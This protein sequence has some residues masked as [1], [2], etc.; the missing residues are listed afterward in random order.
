MLLRMSDGGKHGGPPEDQP[1]PLPPDQPSP[2]GSR[3]QPK[4][5]S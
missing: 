2:D 3:P 5:A 4:P 1:W